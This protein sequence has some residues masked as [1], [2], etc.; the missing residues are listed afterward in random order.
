MWLVSMFVWMQVWELPHN[1][2]CDFLVHV[3]D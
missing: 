3:E 1:V 2:T